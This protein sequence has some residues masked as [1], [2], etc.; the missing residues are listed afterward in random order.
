MSYIRKFAPR[1]FDQFDYVPSTGASGGILVVWNSS[2]F[3]GIVVDK[4]S[5]GITVQITSVHNGDVWFLTNVYGP[6]DDPARTAFINWFKAHEIPNSINWIFLGDFNFYRSLNNR[7][8]LGGNLA[9]TLL[10]NEAIGHLGLIELPLKGRAYTW[11]N[12][13]S[14]PLLEQLDWFF[15]SPNWTL[16]FPNTEV[17]PLAKITSDHI[18]CKIVIST[19]IPRSNIFRFENFWAEHDNF[20]TTVQNSW[21]STADS[22]NAA[23]TLSAKFK[24]LR[25]DLRKWSRNMSNLKLLIENC[26]IVIGY[27]DSLEDT[28][29]LYNPERNLRRLVKTQLQKLLHYKNLYWKKGTQSIELG[30]GMNAQ[31]FFTVWRRY[32]TEGIPLPK[33]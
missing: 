22:V 28:R 33:F 6:C 21:L 20:L 12:M 19:C 30:L 26:N 23:K 5:F 25:V 16:D 15:T 29:L 1:R 32:H 17:L 9:D 7:N 10:F 18:P 4:Q 24:K 2:V 31:N 8:R 13:Q 27:L 3:G 14:D 11:S